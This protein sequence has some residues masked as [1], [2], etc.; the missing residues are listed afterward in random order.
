MQRKIASSG[1]KELRWIDP[2]I[3]TEIEVTEVR[4]HTVPTDVML[5]QAAVQSRMRMKQTDAKQLPI[6]RRIIVKA[7][8]RILCF[9][10]VDAAIVVIETVR[11]IVISIAH[12][13]AGAMTR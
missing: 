8:L 13:A 5:G 3:A 7:A 6:E 9:R 12:I 1:G 10:P 11:E 2:F 4:E